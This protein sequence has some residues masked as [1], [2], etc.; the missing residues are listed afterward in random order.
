M[1][2]T[3]RRRVTFTSTGKWGGGEGGGVTPP[4]T[5]FR[6]GTWIDI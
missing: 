2:E 1:E 4:P 6:T 3:P 5:L